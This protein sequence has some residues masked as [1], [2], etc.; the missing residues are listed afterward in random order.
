MRPIL[1]RPHE[2]S[3]GYLNIHTIEEKDWLV[4]NKN[5][6][7]DIENFRD[8]LKCPFTFMVWPGYE[9][10]VFVAAMEVLGMIIEHLNNHHGEVVSKNGDVVYN[11]AT[12][13]RWIVSTDE[14]TSLAIFLRS[15]STR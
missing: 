5:V 13:E 9:H 8:Y 2:F 3:R 6:A 1:H 7:F 12:G 4:I 11:H 10:H 14:K 15:P